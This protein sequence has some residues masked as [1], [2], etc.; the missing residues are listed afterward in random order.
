MWTR[1]HVF[2][3]LAAAAVFL[4]LQLYFVLAWPSHYAQHTWTG[5]APGVSPPFFTSSPRSQIVASAVLGVMTLV[6]TL[7]PGGRTRLLGTAMWLG[8]LAAIVLVWIATPR[9][10][11]DSD[12]W[13]IDLVLLAIMAG[14]PMLIGRGLGLV[15]RRICSGGTP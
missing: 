14:V 13:P 5:Y 12:L 6:L 8:V 4:A 15:L 1:R 11:G 7:M 10:R 9:L 3:A 2:Y